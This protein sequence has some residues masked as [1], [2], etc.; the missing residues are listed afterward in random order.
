MIFNLDV[1][2]H[3]LYKYMFSNDTLTLKVTFCNDIWRV[4]VLNSDNLL[5]PFE[6]WYA[7]N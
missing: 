7:E 6:N 5:V 3:G 1:H 2:F 4:F